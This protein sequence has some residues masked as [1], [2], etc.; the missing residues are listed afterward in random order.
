MQSWTIGSL[1]YFLVEVTL[2]TM[3]IWLQFYSSI[4]GWH[5]PTSDKQLSRWV[6]LQCSIWNNQIFSNLDR[7]NSC[8]QFWRGSKGNSKSRSRK[9]IWH[10]RIFC[11][12]YLHWPVWKWC[13]VHIH[14]HWYGSCYVVVAWCC[15]ISWVKCFVICKMYFVC[16]TI[17]CMIFMWW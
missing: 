15:L 6:D 11:S 2:F 8:R 5:N 7:T 12:L 9:W 4:L 13:A 14:H 3:C 16:L 17:S 10:R 1:R